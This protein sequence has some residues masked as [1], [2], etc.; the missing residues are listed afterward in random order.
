SPLVD[1]LRLMAGHY[2]RRTSN[3]ALT[4]GLP[5]PKTGITPALFM[6]AAERANMQ[7]R[8]AERSLE[9]LAIAPNL[10]CILVLEHGQACIL[11]DI[12]YPQQHPPMKEEGKDVEI[13]PETKFI[14]QFPET[15][16]E[17]QNLALDELKKLYV[18]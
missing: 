9:S 8:L 13:H 7:A 17:R 3:A 11:W 2:G 4:A 14:V 1:G 10:P 5:I 12:R 16:E 6:R 15:T 18:D